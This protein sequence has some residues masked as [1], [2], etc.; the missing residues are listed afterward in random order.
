M[1]GSQWQ[2]VKFHRHC[3]V[4][5]ASGCR[6]E[7]CQ[8]GPGGSSLFEGAQ[9]KC[10]RSGCQISSDLF[11][12]INL[13]FGRRDTTGPSRWCDE[14][15]WFFCRV[16]SWQCCGPVFW[17]WCSSETA[18]AAAL[19]PDASTLHEEISQEEVSDHQWGKSCFGVGRT[20]SSA[21]ADD[22]LLRTVQGDASWF[23]RM[24]FVCHILAHMVLGV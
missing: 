19:R 7:G 12:G 22:G 15:R 20:I 4:S 6:G 13:Y 24:C 10:L 18:F 9:G 23:W 17:V 14:S 8:S 16:S 11:S 1:F 3:T 21:W 2:T 5:E